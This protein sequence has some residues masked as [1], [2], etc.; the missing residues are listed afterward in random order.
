[1]EPADLSKQE[2]L[3]HFNDDRMPEIIPVSGLLS[4]LI[5]S[6]VPITDLP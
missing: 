5:S 4:S 2:A 1:M 6:A 3:Q